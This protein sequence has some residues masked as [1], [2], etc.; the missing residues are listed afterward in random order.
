M[1][2]ENMLSALTPNEKIAAMDILW[3]DLSATP[4]QIVSPDW[5]GDVLATRSQKPSSEPPLGLD[6]AFDDVRDRLDA[7]RTQG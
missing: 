5:H 4:T 7:R 6:A 3:R 2:L 1:S